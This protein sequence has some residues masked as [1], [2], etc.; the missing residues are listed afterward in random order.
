[1]GFLIVIG[2]YVLG[3]FA[4]WSYAK[5]E[6]CLWDADMDSIRKNWKANCEAARRRRE[7]TD[8][9]WFRDDGGAQ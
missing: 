6:Q 8:R 7:E 2:V 9:E 1:M 4:L 3:Y 5:Y